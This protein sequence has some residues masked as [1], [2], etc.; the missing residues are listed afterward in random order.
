MTEVEG[1]L[2]GRALRIGKVLAKYGLRE[3]AS[4]VSLEDRAVSL[5]TALEE[6]GPTFAKLGQILS[7]RPDLMP[8]EFVAELAKLQ[9]D[10]PPLTE[11]EVVSV[12]EEELGVPWEDVF[13]SIDPEPLAAGT[14]GQ[15][16]RSTLENGDR[17]VVKAQRPTAQGEIL[18]DLGLL[19]LFAQKTENRAAFRQ[20]VDLPAV[21]A[22]LSD[23]LLPALGFLQEP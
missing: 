9:D 7:T 6:L 2:L 8:P 11:A 3:R 17:V 10:V 4:G 13:E 22:R 21:I 15:V 5:R 19:E 1:Q 12:M 20:S 14:I 18:R 16:H 23:S